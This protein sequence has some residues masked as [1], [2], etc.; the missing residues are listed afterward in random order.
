MKIRNALNVKFKVSDVKQWFYCRRVVYFTYCMPVAK[1]ATY[2]MR[3]G[4]EIHQIVADLEKRRTLGRYRIEQG[5]RLFHVSVE[6]DNLGMNGIIDMVVDTS[7]EVIPIEFKNTLYRGRIEAN[8][9]NQLAAYVCLLE[10]QFQKPVRKGYVYFVPGDKVVLVRFNDKIKQEIKEAVTAMRRMVE[11]GIFPEPPSNH[12][13]C[14]DCEYLRYCG[15][16]Y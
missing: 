14:P 15:D 8:H 11:A 3:F 9:R 6:S 13:K 16:R 12:H 1:K 4:K 7:K 2:K 10:D 5:R